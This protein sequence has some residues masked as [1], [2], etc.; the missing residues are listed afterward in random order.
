MPKIP[1]LFPL[2]RK[3]LKNR[4]MPKLSAENSHLFR[5]LHHVGT[6]GTREMGNVEIPFIHA[7]FDCVQS[8]F[9]I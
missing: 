6:S 1:V 4:S 7:T 3:L 8:T 2:P 9:R 5:L